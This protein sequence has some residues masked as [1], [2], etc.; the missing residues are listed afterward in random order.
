MNRSEINQLLRFLVVGC[1]T[2]LIYFII[3][4]IALNLVRYELATLLAFVIVAPI[5]YFAQWGFTFQKRTE[6]RVSLPRSLVWA[7]LSWLA[8]LV[9]TK[10]F[11]GY[12]DLSEN[13][14]VA[15]V[16]MLLS[17]LSFIVSRSWIFLVGKS[18]KSR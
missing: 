12:C 14:A 11:V 7:A 16:T 18:E 1:I 15:L 5:S 17:S 6:H 9:I 4:L 3:S 13:T 10:I 8:S 2:A